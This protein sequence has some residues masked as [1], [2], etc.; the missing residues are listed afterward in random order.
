MCLV[1]DSIFGLLPST[2]KSR[3]R[4]DACLNIRFWPILAAN[5]ESLVKKLAAV[6]FALLLASF[7]LFGTAS[8]AT[9]EQNEASSPIPMF[10]CVRVVTARVDYSTVMVSSDAFTSGAAAVLERTYDFG[11]GI[12]TTTNDD[13]D[14]APVLHTYKKDGD[15]TIAVTFTFL[16]NGQIRTVVDSGCSA[17]FT[18][19]KGTVACQSLTVTEMSNNT[20]RLQPNVAVVG[21]PRITFTYDFG[22]GITMTTNQPFVEHTF[23]EGRSYNVTVDVRGGT[24]TCTGGVVI[25][26]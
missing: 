26:T 3:S 5:K 13:T 4:M 20:Y 7:S 23:M 9:G 1:E 8:A 18:S 6:I 11:D 12:K 25:S 19:A 10:G 21:T 15:Y 2:L 16:V 14:G 24:N 17:T 22:D